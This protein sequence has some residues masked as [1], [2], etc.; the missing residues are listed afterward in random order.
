MYANG[1]QCIFIYRRQSVLRNVRIP[2]TRPKRKSARYLLFKKTFALNLNHRTPR[3]VVVSLENKTQTTPQGRWLS[4]TQVS[5]PF[6]FHA[7]P[8]NENIRYRRSRHFSFLPF[9]RLVFFIEANHW[10]LSENRGKRLSLG[11]VERSHPTPVTSAM[12]YFRE[13]E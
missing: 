6:E 3:C 13:E 2:A 10:H 1:F 9:L 11:R 8:R 12:F 7:R 5:Y 4:L